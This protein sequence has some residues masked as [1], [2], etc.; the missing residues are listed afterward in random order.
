MLNERYHEAVASLDQNY[1]EM[2]TLTDK[3]IESWYELQQVMDE[4]VKFG[5]NVGKK[6]TG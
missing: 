2:K 1:D 5:I 3:L 6:P 4:A